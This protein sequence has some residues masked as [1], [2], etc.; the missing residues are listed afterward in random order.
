MFF[1]ANYATFVYQTL[2]LLVFAYVVRFLPQALGACR[3][4]Y[5]QVNPKTEEAGRGLGK[6]PLPVFA[7]VTIPQMLPGISAGAVLVFLTAMKELPATLLLSPLGF[8]TLSTE[9]WSATTEAFFTRA[10]LPALIL[11]AVSAVPMTVMV[12]QERIRE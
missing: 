1:G 12:L 11:V 9:I 5:L 6:G 10:A 4:S 7:R 8:D 3:A 2:A